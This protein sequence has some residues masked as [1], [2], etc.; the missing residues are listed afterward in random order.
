MCRSLSLKSGKLLLHSDLQL[1]PCIIN[2]LLLQLH[3]LNLTFWS[4]LNDVSRSLGHTLMQ[5]HCRAP[6]NIKEQEG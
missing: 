3:V 6:V 2:K 4:N 1:D 5:E